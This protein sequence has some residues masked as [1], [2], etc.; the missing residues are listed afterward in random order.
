MTAPLACDDR[1]AGR[2]ARA[3]LKSLGAGGL[4]LLL[5]TTAAAQPPGDR[6]GPGPGRPLV[7]PV[8]VQVDRDLNYAGTDDPRQTLDVYRPKSGKSRLLPVI[9]NIHG[10]AFRMGDKG[11]GMAE[12]MGLVTEGSYAVVSINYR[13]SG[14]AQWPAQI[15]DCKAAIRWIRANAGTY[16]FDTDHI[17]VIGAS[18]GGHLAAMLGTSGGVPELEGTVG[19]NRTHSSRVTC[20][21]DQFG[22]SEL[23]AMAEFQ[24]GPRTANDAGSPESQLI[25]GALPDHPDRARAASTTTY[26][27]KDDPPFLI[28]HGTADPLVPFNQSERLARALKDVGV[29]VTFIPVSNAGHGGFRNPEVGVRIKQF[30][31]THL[32]ERPLGPIAETPIPNTPGDGAI[33]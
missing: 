15:H 24:K 5:A 11:M 19:P 6:P 21:V 30:F 25:G 27:T 22:P 16:H 18:A 9:V 4:A 2:P 31:D 28:L 10:G 7:I 26:I 32:I 12:V 1:R 8:T 17:G 3:I 20:V 23:L 14:Q 33:R 29:P 13:L